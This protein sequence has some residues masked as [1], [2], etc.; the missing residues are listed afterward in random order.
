MRVRVQIVDQEPKRYSSF[1]HAVIESAK[2]GLIEY[3]I[4]TEDDL[5][6][7]LGVYKI[8]ITNAKIT[9]MTADSRSEA[10]KLISEL[11]KCLGREI[12]YTYHDGW[13]RAPL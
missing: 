10:K 12:I 7:P 13:I 3:L 4:V 5:K 11:K 8:D 2:D 1:R 6:K 9:I